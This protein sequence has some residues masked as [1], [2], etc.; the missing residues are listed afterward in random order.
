[1]T[2][3]QEPRITVVTPNFNRADD[4]QAT[5]QSVLSGGYSNL[6]YMIMDGG[7]TDDSAAV[8]AQYSNEIAYSRSSR[9]SGPYAAVNEGF[10]R[11]TGDIMAWLNSG[12]L[13]YPWTL[14]IVAE[15]FEQ[16]PEVEWIM[17]APAKVQDRGVHM[18]AMVRPFPRDFLRLGLFAGGEFGIVQQESCFWRRSLWQRAGARLEERYSLAADFELWTRFANHAELYCCDALLS[19]FSIDGKNRSLQAADS[20]NSEVSEVVA[21]LDM[22]ASCQRKKVLGAVA[23]FGGFRNIPVLRG[24]ARRALGIHRWGGQIIRRD[25]CDQRYRLEQRPFW[26]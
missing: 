12:D 11:A 17:G 15:I 5:I 2:V 23:R 26:G 24:L 25:F 21:S 9:D 19:G 22:D 6:E 4:L 20:Y 8:M 3:R 18:V 10:A 7:S 16:Y 1:M 14:R 13:Y